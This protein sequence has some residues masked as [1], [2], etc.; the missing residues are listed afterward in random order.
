MDQAFSPSLTLDITN[1]TGQVSAH[2]E[3][4]YRHTACEQ[5]SSPP[6][7]KAEHNLNKC[8]TPLVMLIHARPRAIENASSI[9]MIMLLIT[10]SSRG[11]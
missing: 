1:V 3:R 2:S 6:R 10:L 11:M 8:N 7:P 4:I 5:V 9:W